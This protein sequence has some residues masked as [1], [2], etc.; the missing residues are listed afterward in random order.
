MIL[1]AEKFYY[2]SLPKGMCKVKWN[3]QEISPNEFHHK[4]NSVFYTAW[5]PF[6][7]FLTGFY[8]INKT[9]VLINNSFLGERMTYFHSLGHLHLRLPLGTSP[10]HEAEPVSTSRNC[11]YHTVTHL[12]FLVSRTQACQLDCANQTPPIQALHK[13]VMQWHEKQELCRISF[14]DGW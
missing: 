14:G 13:E 1:L 11:R 9:A 5:H 6:S 12:A 10:A 3:S 7:L 4:T 8:L 2:L